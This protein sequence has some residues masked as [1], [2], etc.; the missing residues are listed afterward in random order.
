MRAQPGY[1]ESPEV[2]DIPRFGC[3]VGDP[4]CRDIHGGPP[5]A[6]CA[7][8]TVATFDEDK[9]MP[10]IDEEAVTT[11][12][13]VTGMPYRHPHPNLCATKEMNT[14]R[15][16]DTY[17]KGYD[18]PPRYERIQV[19]KFDADDGGYRK[20]KLLELDFG[21]PRGSHEFKAAMKAMRETPEFKEWEQQKRG[22]DEGWSWR[23]PVEPR[24]WESV[25][26]LD[27]LPWPTEPDAKMPVED[28]AAKVHAWAKEE[29]SPWPEAPED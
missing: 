24:P 19:F 28:H 17:G 8:E 16:C 18:A 5:C 1:G 7:S 22:K 26:K 27:A 3:R 29:Y 14:G 11:K 2:G 25:E 4:R 21:P 23:D 6:F 15:G 13:P 9:V 20:G 10:G 12:H